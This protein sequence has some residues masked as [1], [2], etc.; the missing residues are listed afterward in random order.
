MIKEQIDNFIKSKEV[1]QIKRKVKSKVNDGKKWV[2]DH[3]EEAIALAY[4]GIAGI[5][6]IGKLVM[7]QQQTNREERERNKRWYDDQLRQWYTLRRETTN[8]EKLLIDRRHRNGES[9]GEILESMRL[10]K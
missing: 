5:T 8:E 6:S 2:K 9:Y 1:Q 4:V 10:L 3:R 7:K